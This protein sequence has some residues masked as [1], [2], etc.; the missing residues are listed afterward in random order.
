MTLVQ[1]H[2]EGK[3][4]QLTKPYSYGAYNKCNS[5]EQWIRISEGCVWNDPFCYEPTEIKWFGIPEIVRNKV[6]I[7]DMNLLCKPQASETIR[8][9][10]EITV[11]GK[12]VYYELICGVDH[13]FLTEEMAEALFQSRF[14]RIRLAWDWYYKDQFEI[15]DAIEKFLGAGYNREDLMVFMICNWRIP[16]SENLKKLDLLKVWNVKACDCYFD[17]QVSPNIIPIFW[18]DWENRD[19]RRQVRKHNQLVNFKI[20]PEVTP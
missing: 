2:L 5:R 16:Y 4:I 14:K 9:L 3:D 15:K 13:R 17:N 10:G 18:R 8:S 1:Q 12:V 11:R 19:F 20:D 6:R 7:M